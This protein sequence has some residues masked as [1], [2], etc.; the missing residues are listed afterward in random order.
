MIQGA[1]NPMATRHKPSFQLEKVAAGIELF[2]LE[3][4]A[5]DDLMPSRSTINRLEG[6][7]RNELIESE[8]AASTASCCLFCLAV[9]RLIWKHQRVLRVLMAAEW[10]TEGSVSSRDS[11][12]A[13]RETLADA[14]E[15]DT[16][17]RLRRLYLE[18][19]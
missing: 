1:I 7:P 9:F 10:G 2:H 14:V 17:P 12:R 3:E 18:G 15:E 4:I 11:G 13:G 19:S 5:G 6:L 16:G 8:A